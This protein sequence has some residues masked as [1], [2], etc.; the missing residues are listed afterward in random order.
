MDGKPERG[1]VVSVWVPRELRRR[2]LDAKRRA[3]KNGFRPNWSSIASQA[4]AKVI[5]KLEKS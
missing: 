2:M 4:F 5:E 3:D 1:V